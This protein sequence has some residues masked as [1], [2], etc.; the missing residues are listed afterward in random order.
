MY[1]VALLYTILTSHIYY[2]S[3]WSTLLRLIS[4]METAKLGAEPDLYG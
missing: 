3:Y 1:D 4:V 2:V